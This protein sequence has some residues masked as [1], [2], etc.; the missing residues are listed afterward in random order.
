[1]VRIR[2][3]LQ[4]IDE[5]DALSIGVAIGVDAIAKSKKFSKGLHEP[6]LRDTAQL[7]RSIARLKVGCA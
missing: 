6:V 4:D 5:T 1:M 7:A 2:N 3:G